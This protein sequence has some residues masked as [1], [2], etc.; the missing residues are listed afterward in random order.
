MAGLTPF[1][2]LDLNEDQVAHINDE[3]DL[4]NRA[5]QVSVANLR[6]QRSKLKISIP[7]EENDFML[8]LKRFTNLL[9]AVFSDTCPFFK[10][11]VEIVRALK[12]H[13]REARKRMSLATR[14]SI[15]WIVLLQARQFSIRDINLLCKF[16]TMHEDL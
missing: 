3:L 1:A 5:S 9:Y 11:M 12:D 7:A 6:G 8:M 10:A 14:G 16:T 13:S 2:M 4:L 15:L